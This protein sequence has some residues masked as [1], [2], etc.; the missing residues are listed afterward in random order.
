MLTVTVV[1]L[2]KANRILLLVKAHIVIVV[3]ESYIFPIGLPIKQWFSSSEAGGFWKKAVTLVQPIIVFWLLA[4]GHR[5]ASMIQ[6]LMSA[7]S[8]KSTA[9]PAWPQSSKQTARSFTALYFCTFRK[10]SWGRIKANRQIEELHFSRV[11]ER[12][13]LET[14]F[15]CV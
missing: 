7:A 5:A 9:L 1:Y 11:P 4:A 12:C 2:K 13:Y 14:V 15:S 6:K 8:L 3:M 10:W